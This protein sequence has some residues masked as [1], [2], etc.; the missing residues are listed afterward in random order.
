MM[1]MMLGDRSVK[2]AGKVFLYLAILLCFGL[3]GL[4]ANAQ[5]SE[6]LSRRPLIVKIF[7]PE[8]NESTIYISFA[9]LKR[10][11]AGLFPPPPQADDF[12]SP[13]LHLKN[14]LYRYPGRN[15]ARPQ[16]VVFTFIPKDKY[17]GVIYFS[18]NADNAVVHQGE[19]TQEQYTVKEDGSTYQEVAV[20]VPVDI[21]LGL[22]QAKKVEFKVG[23]K[24]YKNSYKLNDYGKKCLAA[25]A[26]T[27]E[28]AS[29]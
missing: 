17:K 2:L 24:S 7:E 16:S 29:K 14:A 12:S 26:D 8:K 27:M 20:V 10:G 1:K 11:Y 5:T 6:M 4:F 18:V 23:P 21:F 15:P 9:D 28:K 13:S 22:V 25:L 19:M 3:S